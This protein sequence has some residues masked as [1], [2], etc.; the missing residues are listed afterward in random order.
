MAQ[1]Q[2]NKIAAPSLPVFNELPLIKTEDE[3]RLYKDK[4]SNVEIDKPNPKFQSSP[5]GGTDT[6][7]QN[8]SA[9]LACIC[10]SY[11]LSKLKTILGCTKIR[12]VM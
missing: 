9:Q 3:F 1:T 4:A 12:Q 6:D 8:S 10:L 7:K 2:T 5:L 11:R